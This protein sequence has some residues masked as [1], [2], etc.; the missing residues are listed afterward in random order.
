MNV[1]Q[2]KKLLEPLSDENIVIMSKDGEGNYFSP[3]ADIE[4]AIYIPETTWYG[5]IR[6]ARFL[7]PDLERK[8][9]S[10]EDTAGDEGRSAIVLYPIG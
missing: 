6:V 4:L 5:E 1:G 2:L 10:E 7:T 8:G 9:Y 3:L